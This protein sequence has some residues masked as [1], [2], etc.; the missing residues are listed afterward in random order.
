MQ[1]HQYFVLNLACFSV[2]L[3]NLKRNYIKLLKPVF[4]LY[5][6]TYLKARR[7]L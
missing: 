7:G 5:M 4:N 2:P 3:M 1:V 6:I